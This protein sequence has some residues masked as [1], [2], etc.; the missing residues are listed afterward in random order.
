M[1]L[2]DIRD[3]YFNQILNESVTIE[4]GKKD[5][6]GDDNVDQNKDGLNN[7][8]DVMIARMIKSGMSKK[9]A[10]A[11]VEGNYDVKPK[12][13]TNES[14]SN[15]RED[16]HEVI[17]ELEKNIKN[18][19]IKEKNVNNYST[20]AINL[21]PTLGNAVAES[22]GG[23][24]IN[25]F[26]LD[27]EYIEEIID[28]ASQY[29]YEE[30]LNEDG[31]NILI[32][33]LGVD[34]FYEWV[35][36]IGH[37]YLLDEETLQGELFTKDLKPRKKPEVSKRSGAASVVTHTPS[38]QEKETTTPIKQ[39]KGQTSLSLTSSR[40]QRKPGGKGFTPSTTPRPHRQPTGAGVA[41]Q[42]KKEAKQQKFTQRREKLKQ[43]IA[44]A[45]QAPRT[46][47]ITSSGR[48]SQAQPEDNRP[49]RT[50]RTRGAALKTARQQ[51]SSLP[52][53]QQR[54][55]SNVKKTV[56]SA[57]SPE[58]VRKT[59]ADLV[60]LAQRERQAAQAFRQA[61][62][63][64]RGV[65]A[66]L[67][68]FLLKNEFDNWVN[69]LL[70]EGYDLSDYTWDELYEEFEVLQ[71]KAVSEQQQKLFGL[72]LAYKRGEV[73]KS[74]VSKQVINLANSMSEKELIKYASTKHKDV[75]KTV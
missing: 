7:F 31:V 44:S 15:W 1:M 62:G 73:S 36:E 66:G 24:V 45:E 49:G 35:M 63:G 64:L 48:V 20:K 30:G 9:E 61:G 11:Y 21:K 51:Q 74:K 60:T 41:K 13:Q 56:S 6:P 4:P 5:I 40:S 42:A 69:D 22:F 3:I 50:T 54:I 57:T 59:V 72:A 70:D 25:E 28:A 65:G 23:E 19:Q 38:R 71:E 10:I 12:V 14:F 17:D 39:S 58:S 53:G 27:E 43:N 29:F 67:R 2:K 16:L 32:E 52:Q 68:S 37:N 75:P 34:E 55:I 8:K 18:S 47:R 26:E 46:S 33:E